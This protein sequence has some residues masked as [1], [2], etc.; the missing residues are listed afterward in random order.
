MPVDSNIFAPE[1]LYLGLGF[2]VVRIFKKYF[3]AR[4]YETSQLA[5]APS[6]YGI[7]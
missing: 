3:L 1:L 4:H 7:R 6:L 5:S 2:G